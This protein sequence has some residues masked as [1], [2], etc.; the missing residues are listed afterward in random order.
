MTGTESVLAEGLRLPPLPFP[1][2][3]LTGDALL[4]RPGAMSATLDRWRAQQVARNSS[5]RRPVV[6][7]LCGV[8]RYSVS[9]A[10]DLVPYDLSSVK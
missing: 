8:A 5:S 3:V 2:V 9:L 7:N 6:G 4:S 1:A 10:A